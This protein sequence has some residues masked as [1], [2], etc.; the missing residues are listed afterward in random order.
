MQRIDNKGGM[1]V[2]ITGNKISKRMIFLS[3]FTTK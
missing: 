1:E 3:P 2:Q